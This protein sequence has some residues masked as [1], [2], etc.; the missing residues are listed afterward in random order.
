MRVPITFRDQP[1]HERRDH[2]HGH[3]SFSRCEAAS[4][5]HIIEFETPAL[6]DH[7]L[8]IEPEYNST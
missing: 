1:Q 8:E 6:F 3:S 4:L 5:P 7:D 2:E